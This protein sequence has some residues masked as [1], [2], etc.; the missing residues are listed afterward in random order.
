M[1]TNTAAKRPHLSVV[2]KGKPPP[3]SDSVFFIKAQVKLG[4]HLLCLGR[5]ERP[6]AWIVT[7]IISHSASGKPL[8]LDEV[9]YLS[10]RVYLRRANGTLAHA[11]RSGTFGYLS[12]SAIWRI[13]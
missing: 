2:P 10:D 9:Q 1:H 5:R 7:R 3:K 4:T 6:T 12:Y 13:A 11:E 8:H